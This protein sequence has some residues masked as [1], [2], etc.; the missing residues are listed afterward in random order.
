MAANATFLKGLLSIPR[1]LG[2]L[3]KTPKL[4]GLAVV[5]AVLS[6]MLLFGLAAFSFPLGEQLL[7]WAWP[8]P[9]V[10]AGWLSVLLTVLRWLGRLLV[11][12]LLLFLSWILTF[13][14]S[15]LIAEP[16]VDLLSEGTEAAVAPGRKAPSFSWR[17]LLK[18]AGHAIRDV[19]LDIG[20]FLVIQLAILA[21]LLVPVAGQVL[22]LLL[23][24]FTGAFFA[25]L[26]MTSPAWGRRNVRGWKRYRKLRRNLS[27][28]LGVGTGILCVMLV[29]LA[30]LFTLPIAVVGGTLAVLHLD[31]E[32]AEP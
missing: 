23:G 16:F 8:E 5:P 6:L 11:W 32:P 24:W 10:Q 30:Q 28:T 3:L 29:P 17:R 31:P 7:D 25:A 22:H 18:E 12:A 26:E 27:F 19:T 21:L 20:L 1:G 15:M 2:L 4:L 13:F 9:S 14:A